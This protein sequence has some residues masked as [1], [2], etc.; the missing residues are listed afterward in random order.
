V[1][2]AL[3]RAR[4]STRMMVTVP[5]A[6]QDATVAGAARGLD[7]AAG[8][9]GDE[10]KRDHGPGQ[11]GGRHLGERQAGGGRRGVGDGGRLAH[12]SKDIDAVS[13]CLGS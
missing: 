10:G 8:L 4:D 2:T 5:G 13:G 1:C 9:V 7:G 3:I 6:Q 11:D 12:V